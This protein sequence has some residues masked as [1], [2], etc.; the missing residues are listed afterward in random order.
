MPST[1]VTYPT[2]LLD[3]YTALLSEEGLDINNFSSEVVEELITEYRPLL[4]YPEKLS[5][6]MIDDD[7]A[8][9]SCPFMR[10]DRKLQRSV[11]RNPNKNCPYAHPLTGSNKED[12]T[13]TAKACTAY[14]YAKRVVCYKCGEKKLET[15]AKIEPA[16]PVVEAGDK[17]SVQI[18]FTLKAQASLAQ[19]VREIQKKVPRVE[20]EKEEKEE[21]KEETK[22]EETKEEET[23]EGEEKTEEQTEEKT[24]ETAMEEDTETVENGVN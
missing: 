3:S 19:F 16:A 8:N 7:S 4:S 12:W 6:Q 1:D 17:K 18:V 14:N 13:C 9:V 24:E 22:E 10:R 11:C 2:C 15:V 20:K 21:Q 23:K 5:C